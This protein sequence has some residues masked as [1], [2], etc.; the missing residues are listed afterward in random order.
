M[1]LKELVMDKKETIILPH[2]LTNIEIQQY[3]EN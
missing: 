1:E 2:Q 3:Y